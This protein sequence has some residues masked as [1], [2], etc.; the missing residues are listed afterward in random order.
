VIAKKKAKK[1]KISKVITEEIISD[2]DKSIQDDNSS[3]ESTVSSNCLNETNDSFCDNSKA[4]NEDKVFNLKEEY[5]EFL[6]LFL[7]LKFNSNNL[8]FL[9]KTFVWNEIIKNKIPKTKWKDFI[10]N[11]K[12][13]EKNIKKKFS[14]STVNEEIKEY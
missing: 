2:V 1:G 7:K 3:V 11:F 8:N 13:S 4:K 9:D 6:K 5:K 10:M 14:G 12:I